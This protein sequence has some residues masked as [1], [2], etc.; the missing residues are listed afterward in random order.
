LIPRIEERVK[1][2]AC[3]RDDAHEAHGR[4]PFRVSEEKKVKVNYLHSD[5]KT[6]TA[7]RF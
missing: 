1:K 3:A 6:L 5:V 7:S 4:G 2:G